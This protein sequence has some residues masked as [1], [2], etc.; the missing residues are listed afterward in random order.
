MRNDGN[1]Y[2]KRTEDKTKYKGKKTRKKNTKK[3][4]FSNIQNRYR[5]GI[6]G[7]VHDV[8]NKTIFGDKLLIILRR[9]AYVSCEGYVSILQS[10]QA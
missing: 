9:D 5:T 4:K 6:P 7:H 2:K 3:K 10:V 8:N 1:M